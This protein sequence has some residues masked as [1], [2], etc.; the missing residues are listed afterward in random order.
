MR[1]LLCSALLTLSV[2]ALAEGDAAG[3]VTARLT[4]F[5][6]LHAS[7]TEEKRVE[8]L[9]KPLKST[10]R[11]AYERTRGLLWLV[12]KPLASETVMTPSKLVQKVKG[13]VTVNLNVAAQPSMQVISRLFLASLTGDWAALD[14]DFAMTGE[15]EP[16][17]WKLHL[18]PK[19][20]LFAK[21]AKTLELSGDKAI[22]QVVLNELSGDTTTTIFEGHVFD[23]PLTA[24]EEARF[25]TK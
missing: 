18:K 6:T 1:A 25:V 3:Q 21:M 24:D 7:F 22:R 14:A 17:G 10:G 11:L 13:R 2:P 16:G 9:T 19:G 15:V 8:G 4:P 23:V 12:E 20:G 5:K